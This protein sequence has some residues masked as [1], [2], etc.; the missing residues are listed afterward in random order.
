MNYNH[1]GSC[2]GLQWL[3][4]ANSPHRIVI[5]SALLA[6]LAVSAGGTIAV[7]ASESVRSQQ[8]LLAITES[9]PWLPLDAADLSV[10]VLYDSGL[11]IFREPRKRPEPELRYRAGRLTA[12]EVKELLEPLA[13]VWV[14][15][16]KESHEL[17]EDS[18]QPTTRVVVWRARRL[19]V[20]EIY[21]RLTPFP[22]GG[23]LRAS[24][25]RTPTALGEVPL[26]IR[27]VVALSER[28]T[29]PSESSWLPDR[30]EVL[31]EPRPRSGRAAKPWPRHWPDLAHPDTRRDRRGFY[32]I[33]LPTSHLREL[34]ALVGSFHSMQIVRMSGRHMAIAYRFPLPQEH[35]WR[36]TGQH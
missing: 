30:I 34:R 35:L 33:F 18:D 21:G 9:D 23:S 4:L 22:G 12:N 36:G 31:A 14:A 11:L 17:T 8:P 19:K 32:R 25:Y 1:S 26:P 2:P 16:T 20:V 15:G 28:F 29:H 5:L 24:Y 6:F 3:S 27:D 10:F 7:A 13:K